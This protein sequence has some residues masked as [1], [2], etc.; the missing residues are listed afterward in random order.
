MGRGNKEIQI[1]GI[2]EIRRELSYRYYKRL[3]LE[4]KEI[5]DNSNLTPRRLLLAIL[6]YR[7]G[8]NIKRSIRR[9]KKSENVPICFKVELNL[10]YV[11]SEFKFQGFIPISKYK[12]FNPRYPHI[13]TNFLID[14]E[15]W[16]YPKRFG[17]TYDHLNKGYQ[18]IENVFPDYGLT[19]YTK[20]LYGTD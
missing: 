19:G 2:W 12:K 16:I 4:I 10:K 9:A 7:N 5:L 14:G 11:I 13:T 20:I 1:N 18:L 6:L 3:P 8:I 17:S 15:Y